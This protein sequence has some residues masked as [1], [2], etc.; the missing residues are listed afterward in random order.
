MKLVVITQEDRFVIPQNIE[1]IL[2]LEGVEVA[3]IATIDDRSSLENRKVFFSRG[4]GLGQSWRLGRR[5]LAARLANSV[6]GLFGYRLLS[7]KRSINA[8]AK[9]HRIPFAK[10]GNPNQPAFLTQL[11]QL[12]PDL[13]VSLSA[14]CIFRPELLGL[15]PHGCINLH[16][17][18]LPRFAGVFPGFWALYQNQR[19]TGATVHYMDTKIDNGLILGQ[20]MVPIEQGMSVFELVHRTKAAGGELLL[21]VIKKFQRGEIETKP[22]RSEEGSY[23]S[24]PSIE[25]MREFRGRG[26]RFV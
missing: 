12:S 14:P 19:E 22:N 9:K 1:K 20:V 18:P 25:Q 26:G 11:R 3:L 2:G 7:R 15:P 13:I 23:F 16:C 5:W 6:D 4:L 21:E 10:V 8:V 24:W 17:S